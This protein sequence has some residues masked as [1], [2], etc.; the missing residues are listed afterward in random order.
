MKIK[1][2]FLII[3]A[4]IVYLGCVP[5]SSKMFIQANDPLIEYTLS[6]DGS[7]KIALISVSGVIDNTPRKNLFTQQPGLV[8]EFISH[9]RIAEYDKNVK[10]ILLKV[11]SPGGTITASDIIYKE[12]VE[13]KK[14]TGK[15]IIVIMMDI[16]TSGGYY[17]SLPADY[18]VA[19]PTTVTGSIG[20]VFIH[21]NVK[22]LM[23]KLGIV[24]DVSKSG[25]NKDIG[26][27]FRDKSK[28]ELNILNNLVKAMGHRFV[29]LVVKHRNLKVHQTKNIATARIYLAK[30][31]LRLKLIDS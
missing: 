9:L 20:A 2:S 7:D 23:A 1:I 18:I 10:A 14:R 28:E 26:S 31:A 13:F 30:D 27:P 5:S 21:P 15:K 4:S 3:L 25:K 29:N 6:G 24:M 8:Q 22:G 16:A 11:D 17:I 19:H 12:L